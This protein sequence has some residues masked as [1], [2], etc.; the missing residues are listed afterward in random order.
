MNTLLQMTLQFAIVVA[1]NSS[2]VYAQRRYKLYT[3]VFGRYDWQAHVILLSVIWLAFLL[4]LI[5]IQ[6]PI[7]Q[8]PP[9]LR[10]VGIVVAALGIWLVIESWL[11]LGTTGTCNGWFFGRGPTKQL[12]GGVFKLRNPMYS[13]FVLLFISAAFWLENAAYLWLAI[14]SFV[15]LNLIQARVERPLTKKNVR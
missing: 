5:F 4:A 7:W 9:T 11:I 3:R 1:V 10:L 8:L 2:A 15:L 12:A 6:L 14:V 13:G